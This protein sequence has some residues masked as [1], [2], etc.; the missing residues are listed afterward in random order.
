MTR[1]INLGCGTNIMPTTQPEHHRLIPPTL[2]TDADIQWDN[3]DWNAGPGVNKVVDLFDY[4][5]REQEQIRG[6]DIMPGQDIMEHDVLLPDN[7][8]DMALVA[9]ICEHIP[10]HIVWDGKFMHRHPEYQDGWFAWFAQLWR[11]M[12][13]G[14]KVYVLCPFVWSDS[15]QMDPTHT[16]YVGPATF[17]YFNNQTDEAPA[18]RYRM[19]QRWQVSL[20][21]IAWTPHNYA[22]DMVRRELRTL[23]ELTGWITEGARNVD[24]GSWVYG[25]NVTADDVEVQKGSYHVWLIGNN[26]INA[27]VEF[28]IEM[29]AVKE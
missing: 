15:G 1:G 13:P 10:H 8:Y 12:K 3:V 16:R 14:G 6:F 25:D 17:N 4:P 28:M 24:I 2:Y 26:H 29:T 19:A 11:V 21:Q 22:I 20:E 18:F 5:W 27:I 9:H 23:A 7:T